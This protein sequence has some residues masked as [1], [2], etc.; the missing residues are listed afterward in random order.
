MQIIIKEGPAVTTE[1]GGTRG[2]ERGGEIK[3]KE[4]GI[5]LCRYKRNDTHGLIIA[6]LK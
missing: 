5:I 3:N 2:E 1:R 4:G 6:V